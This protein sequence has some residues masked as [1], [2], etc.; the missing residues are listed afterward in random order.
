MPAFH[1]LGTGGTE[2]HD[3]PVVGHLRQAHGGHRAHR[4]GA[5]GHLHDGGADANLLGLGQHPGRHGDRI[6]TVGLSGPHGVVAQAL[7]VL[8]EIDR[9]VDLLPGIAHQKS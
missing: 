8:D 3:K 7:R 5:G 4:R 1:H 6:R 9:Y 2:A